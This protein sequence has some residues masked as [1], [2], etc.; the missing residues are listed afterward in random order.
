MGGD[1]VLGFFLLHPLPCDVVGAT[2]LD[3]WEYL[4]I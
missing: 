3:P 1:S 2:K 4:L